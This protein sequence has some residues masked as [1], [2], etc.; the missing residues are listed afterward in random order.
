[1]Q[2]DPR[3]KQYTPTEER[4]NIAS[5]AFGAVLSL[6]AFILLINHAVETGQSK[7]VFSFGI[8]GFSLIV[9]YFAST[10][11]HSST[12][13][14]LRIRMRV[15]DHASIYVLIA[16]TYTPFTLI[17]LNS[18]LGW[19]LFFVSWGLA[20]SGVT[21]KLFFTG[22]YTLLSTLMYVVMGWLIIVAIKPLL[23]SL[24][25]EGLFWLALGGLCYTLG[26]AIY[27]IKG[28]KYNHAIFH[29]LVLSGSICHFV[30]VYFFVL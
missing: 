20:I 23:E 21:L 29:L 2:A 19:T 6:V 28:I 16:G 4:I 12:T 1:M 14:A 8:F 22:R 15:V 25:S 5:H 7:V 3:I 9:L 18:R 30:S 24:S 13:A 17:T 10:I 11:Y 26:A 27:A